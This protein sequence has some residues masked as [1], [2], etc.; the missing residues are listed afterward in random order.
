[1]ALEA[2]IQDKKALKE[3]EDLLKKDFEKKRDLKEGSVVKATVSEIGKKFVVLNISGG[4][5]DP[6]VPVE[7][8][9]GAGEF[10]NLKVNSVTD[11]FVE[12][13]DGPNGIVVSRRR[14]KLMSSWK[15]IKESF[16]KEEEVSAI[17]KSRT[18]GGYF[19]LIDNS[20]A[21]FC[22]GSQISSK[23]L[24]NSEIDSLMNV[25]M[26]FL[27]VKMDTSRMN[28]VI[29]R[30]AIS[31]KTRSRDL[32][33][34][35]SKIKEGDVIKSARVKAVESF[36]AFIDIGDDKTG[37]LDALLHQSDISYNRIHKVS[38]FLSQGDQI[39]VKILKIDL[40]T[41]RVSVGCKQLGPDPWENL[42]KRF[43]VNQIIE[44]TVSKIVTFGV[45]VQV[46]E[47][48]QGLCHNSELD[49]LNRDPKP[50][51]ILSP[52]Q[53][54]KF[55]IIELD[56]PKKRMSLSYKLAN[57]K[58][59]WD[60][61]LEKYP[62]N[63]IVNA[64]TVNIVD[65]GIFANIE[66]TNLQ[67]LL[68]RNDMTINPKEDDIKKY[69]KNLKFKAKIVEVDRSK[70]KIRISVRALERDPFDYFK[71]K[72][73]GEVITVKVQSVLK[74]AIKVSPGNEDK[75]EIIIK[76]NQLGK[77]GRVD[78]YSVGNRIDCLITN[79]RIDR[80]TVDL[81]IKELEIQNEKN[82]EQ[83]FGKAGSKSGAVLGN[84]LGK[85]FKSQKT[86]KKK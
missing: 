41:S 63:S 10:E 74:N 21:A 1:M 59:P 67:A 58:N 14:A 66:D 52:S 54:A 22:P 40:E 60:T 56:I 2:D 70:E 72:K 55:K 6:I 38:D 81:S 19:C 77:D 79:L 50:G 7:E 65:F 75:L 86:K 12:R 83:K 20:Y 73:N 16:E 36:G 15:R 17:V 27:V 78:V 48:L 18:R 11:V 49:F 30:K 4:K 46:S 85:V 37:P 61:L 26:K 62:V 45:F 8:F 51:T 13:I 32:K 76:K 23:P 71:N 68:H 42:E 25:P 43:S 35:L 53:K 47:N 84:I 69:K 31:D 24:Q 28:V 29:S 5:S 3:F 39:S 82:L 34:V 64:T 33:K 57:G 44:G 80:R 9:R